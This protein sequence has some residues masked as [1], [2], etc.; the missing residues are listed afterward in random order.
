MNSGLLLTISQNKNDSKCSFRDSL[1]TFPGNPFSQIAEH[2]LEIRRNGKISMIPCQLER[3]MS[4]EFQSKQHLMITKHL[5]ISLLFTIQGVPQIFP[6]L[7]FLLLDFKHGTRP[8]VWSLLRTTKLCINHLE[9][10]QNFDQ[11]TISPMWLLLFTSPIILQ[12]TTWL[13]LRVDM[14]TSWQQIVCEMTHIECDMAFCWMHIHFG[15]CHI[16][17]RVS[18]RFMDYNNSLI[19]G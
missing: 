11:Y 15:A 13:E 9:T 5:R 12:V 2:S 3:L 14:L 4:F 8:N 18:N 19:F 17:F 6:I 16:E 7:Y 10:I 1:T